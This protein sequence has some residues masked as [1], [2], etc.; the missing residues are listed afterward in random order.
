[1]EYKDILPTVSVFKAHELTSCI[2]C[3]KCLTSS[4]GALRNMTTRDEFSLFL[5]ENNNNTTSLMPNHHHHHHHHHSNNNYHYS[6]YY[7]SS[8]AL[9]GLAIP[10]SE[11]KGRSSVHD[12]IDLAWVCLN[13][14]LDKLLGD[15]QLI[16][17]TPS[18]TAFDTG[19]DFAALG[20]GDVGK[21][22]AMYGFPD[23][24]AD[25]ALNLPVRTEGTCS[26]D[27][28][29]LHCDTFRE[30]LSTSGSDS[31]SE[32]DSDKSESE[33]EAKIPEEMTSVIDF[34][35]DMTDLGGASGSPVIIRDEFTGRD[36]LLGINFAAKRSLLGYAIHASRLK[37]A[38]ESRSEILAE[39]DGG[40]AP[41]TPPA[42]PEGASGGGVAGAGLA[43]A[44]A[45]GPEFTLDNP[46]ALDIFL[47]RALTP[48]E[49]EEMLMT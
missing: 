14:L 15:P 9:S 43:G 42:L 31:T 45:G 36:L 13:P 47:G 16:G 34:K 18:F 4:C 49:V 25:R 35:M 32:D 30:T 19:W 23:G 20:V 28:K 46:Q 3:R 10:I 6:S 22:I 26:T 29:N 48:A 38:L 33:E 8:S 44:G 1:M 37:L 7:S 21:M 39:E 11:R 12:E 40:D 2:N 5:R 41:F 27:P 24:A 17:Y